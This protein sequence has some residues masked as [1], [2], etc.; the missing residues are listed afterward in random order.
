MLYNNSATHVD[1]LEYNVVPLMLYSSLQ[2]GAAGTIAAY[3]NG[4]VKVTCRW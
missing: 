3:R 1:R 4:P 2:A